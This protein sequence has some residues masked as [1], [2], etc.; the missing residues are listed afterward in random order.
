[1][2]KAFAQFISKLSSG[3][4]NILSKDPIGGLTDVTGLVPEVSVDALEI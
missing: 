2:K 4:K 3:I 1:M